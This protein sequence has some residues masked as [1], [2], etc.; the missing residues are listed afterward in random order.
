MT[1]EV[2]LDSVAYSEFTGGKSRVR[3][4]V[5][6]AEGGVMSD[7]N[8]K[9]DAIRMENHSLATINSFGRCVSEE[10]LNQ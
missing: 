1:N 6:S 10:V 2:L 7:A 9:A 3:D 5:R 4:I 8:T